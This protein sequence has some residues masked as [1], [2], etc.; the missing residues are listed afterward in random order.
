M[1]LSDKQLRRGEKDSSSDAEKVAVAEVKITLN[2]DWLL[3][4]SVSYSSEIVSSRL[5]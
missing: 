5:F 2:V 3:L 1:Q 4:L